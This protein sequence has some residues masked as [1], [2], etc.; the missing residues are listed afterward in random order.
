MC[1]RVSEVGEVDAEG[2]EA[3]VVAV[4]VWDAA[5]W[6]AVADVDG[7]EVVE[8][9]EVA[10]VAICVALDADTA[11]AAVGGAVGPFGIRLTGVP[12][13]FLPGQCLATVR[14]AVQ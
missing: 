7:E 13:G 3:E 5:V 4:A 1:R 10:V 12:V 14:M 2:V 6:D 9:S 8:D 11:I